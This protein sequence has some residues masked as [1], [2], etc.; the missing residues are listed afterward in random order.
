M[1]RRDP[2]T[3]PPARILLLV[4]FLFL[5]NATLSPGQESDPVHSESPQADS[6]P[7]SK[8]NGTS[9]EPAPLEIKAIPLE[10]IVVKA[11]EAVE[12]F[13]GQSENLKP[14]RSLQSI[15]D[16]LPEIARDLGRIAD[17]IGGID[18]ASRAGRQLTRLESE[19]N[20]LQNR[21]KGWQGELTDR[22]RAIQ[23]RLSALA[24][25]RTLWSNTRQSLSNDEVAASLVAQVDTVN[26]TIDDSIKRNNL[27][28]DEALRLQSAVSAQSNRLSAQLKE[29]TRLTG[30]GR[31][32]LLQPDSP[33]IWQIAEIHR[34]DQDL[35]NQVSSALRA[36]F[37]TVTEFV[38]INPV[39]LAIQLIILFLVAAYLVNV[40]R[41]H[42]ATL[43]NDPR[44]R[45]A[46]R[47]LNH[48]V[49]AAIVIA[50]LLSPLLF[51][52]PPIV[53]YRY[54]VFLLLIPVAILLQSTLSPEFKRMAYGTIVCYALV[55]FALHL[56]D[57]SIVQRLTE[58]MAAVFGAFVMFRQNLESKRA[59]KIAG[60]MIRFDRFAARIGIVIFP[61]AV[62]TNVF[63]L[64]V[65]SDKLLSGYLN[66]LIIGLI[67]IAGSNAIHEFLRIAMVVG[68]LRHFSAIRLHFAIVDRTLTRI[69][70]F[71]VVA[72]WA[73]V[74]LVVLGLFSPLST[75]VTDV[76][77]FGWKAGALNLTVGSI[78]AFVITIWVAVMLSK[79][80]RF[81]VD[82]D[83]LPRL[84][85]PRGIPAT[86]SMFINYAI[87]TLGFIIALAAAG[88][89]L[90]QISIL[91]GALGVGIGFG[92]QNLVNNFVSGLIL[93]FERPIKVGDKIQFGTN[94]GEVKSIGI[95]A[96]NVRSFDGA[97]VIVPN[98]NL[99]SIEVTNWTLSDQQRRID[100]KVGVAY[101]TDPER[102]IALLMRVLSQ[103]DDVMKEPEPL[104]TFDAFGESSLDF[105]AR[106]W[107]GD[108]S[109][110]LRLKS[111]VLI[112]VSKAL[113][114]DGI[115]IPFPQRDL[116]VRTV[117]SA[118][119]RALQA[120]PDPD[121]PR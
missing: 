44:T 52:D 84:D 110:G 9:G 62:L 99:I 98:G 85:L 13:A 68:P 91:I 57:F 17:D 34:Q 5:V 109:L 111:A 18:N 116:H 66:I 30:I 12:T 42:Q 80:I 92:L 101:G 61:F 117:D 89:H 79:S 70:Q 39:N 100:V 28:R 10:E 32:E 119:A 78:L 93:I 6:A 73:I 22:L 23:V 120:P 35:G 36:D 14:A 3:T 7:S 63:G 65:L 82:A 27:L 90:S 26:E 86:I 74:I 113:A 76:L 51:R 97:E 88:I 112:A 114:E 81:I 47:V 56:P 103:F 69:L 105:T 64:F 53:F 31:A 16:D 96:S 77:G 118:A 24:E 59:P 104:I 87:I 67:L 37:K 4:S 115:E 49:A 33:F 55:R 107:T 106:F 8:T 38:R 1:K 71:V 72:S 54:A 15:K 41:R 43:E 25:A 2:L 75:V 95:R 60:E 83:I 58:L 108:F 48:P 29:L 121:A 46:A 11:Q 102:V 45:S 20:N 94:F 21:L 19:L 50:L 40:R